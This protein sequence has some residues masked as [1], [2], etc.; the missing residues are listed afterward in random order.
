MEIKIYSNNG[1]LVAQRHYL[2]GNIN[3]ETNDFLSHNTPGVF[4]VRI[5]YD[6]IVKTRKLR[7][8]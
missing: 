5:M 1:E 3:S 2:S 8:K 7:I 6:G 4:F